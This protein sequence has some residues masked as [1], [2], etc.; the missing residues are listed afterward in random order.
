MT[1]APAA[2]PVRP[3]F[4]TDGGQREEEVAARVTA[5]IDQAQATLEIALYDLRLAGSAAAAVLEAVERAKARGVRARLVFNQ[6]HHAREPD[7]APAA[8][9]WDLIHRFGVP[10]QPISGV[11]DLMHHKYVVRDGAAVLTGSSNWTNDSWTREENVILTIDSADLAEAYLRDF[12][13]LWQR[14][15]VAPSGHFDVP[16][17]ELGPTTHGRAFFSPG[18]GPQLAH[19]IARRIGAA[20]RRIRVVSPVITAGPILGTLCDVVDSRPQIV[21]GT[22]DLTQMEQVKEQWSSNPVAAWK[23]HALATIDGA[24]AFGRKRSTPWQVGSVHDFMHAKFVVADDAVLVGSYN[25][26]HSG[27][28][29]AENVVELEDAD[30]ADLFTRFA[31]QVTV[32]YGGTPAQ[33]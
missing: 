32:K 17:T 12:E 33:G 19:E 10:F 29:N 2:A 18:R 25:L 31:D 4:L 9:D 24:V 13:D 21:S 11:P 22:Y 28:E 23:L 30:L 26:S 15:E 7:P 5:F 8:V 1:E 3:Y 6:D 16:W 27:E 14:R 20:R